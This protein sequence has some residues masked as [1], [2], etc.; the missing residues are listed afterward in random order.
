MPFMVHSVDHLM[1]FPF[2]KCCLSFICITFVVLDL[3]GAI[4][5]GGGET[6]DVG[7]YKIKTGI[8]DDDFVGENKGKY[9]VYEG[10]YRIRE[11]KYR[12]D[13]G[14]Y[15]TVWELEKLAR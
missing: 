7:K 8:F 3:L 2:Q 1:F 14:K 11:P 4:G 12:L 10:K 13:T 9:S 15:N 5:K 6:L